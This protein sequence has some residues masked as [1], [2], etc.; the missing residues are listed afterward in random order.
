MTLEE[1]PAL[2]E[3]VTVTYQASA[4]FYCGSATL[5]KARVTHPLAVVDVIEELLEES[6]ISV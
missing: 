6:L 2:Y 3:R 4:S 1:L 5:M